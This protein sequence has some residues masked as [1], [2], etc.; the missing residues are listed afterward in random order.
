MV[1]NIKLQWKNK[2]YMA[3]FVPIHLTFIIQTAKNN[4]HIFYILNRKMNGGDT[5]IGM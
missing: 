5:E 1:R 3:V 4:I 2:V